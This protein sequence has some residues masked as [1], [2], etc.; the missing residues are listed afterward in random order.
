M[1]GKDTGNVNSVS[2]R[3]T[4]T[5]EVW[6]EPCTNGGISEVALHHAEFALGI[7]LPSIELDSLALYCL[8]LILMRP[9]PVYVS[10]NAGVFEVYNG[11]VDEESG[12]GRWVKNVEVIIFDPRTIELGEGCAHAWRGIEYLGSPCLQVP[13]R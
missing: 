12:C 5:V 6:D 13:T 3:G 9:I 8:E 2:G 10:N 7:V 4:K 11:V 1:S